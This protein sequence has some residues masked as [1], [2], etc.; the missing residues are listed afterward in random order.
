MA[1]TVI[2]GLGN[3]GMTYALN[4]HNIGFLTLD[5]LAN[6][7]GAPNFQRR[8]TLEETTCD[9]G[10]WQVTLIKPLSFMN[11][12]G[13]PVSE[14]KNFYKVDLKDIHV[15]HDDLDLDFLKVRVKTGGGHGGHNGLKSLD[16][17]M[18]KEYNRIRIGI[19]HPG[20]KSQVNS[21]VLGNFSAK[22][23]D[24]LPYFLGTFADLMPLYLKDSPGLFQEK[25]NAYVAQL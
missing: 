11:R 19:D 2:V 3:P 7:Y 20:D 23:Q 18:G 6:A 15:I 21:H 8:G 25:I 24:L 12:S 9:V 22:E 16:A 5:V 1:K 13:I 10:G 14:Y 4:R 17:H